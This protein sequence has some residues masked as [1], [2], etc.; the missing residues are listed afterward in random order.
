MEGIRRVSLN[1]G[2]LRILVEAEMSKHP[3]CHGCT[4]WSVEAREPDETGCNWKFN[5]GAGGVAVTGCLDSIA[6]YITL[7][8]ENFRLDD[9]WPG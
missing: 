3:E 7:L 8:Q 6:K 2:T 4:R 9:R 5:A 1:A